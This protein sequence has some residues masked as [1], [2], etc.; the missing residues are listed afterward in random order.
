MHRFRFIARMR[1]VPSGHLLCIDT[2][3]ICPKILL[4]DNEDS[5]Q[6]ARMHKNAQ[7]QVHRTHAQSS[8]RAFAL[9][10]YILYMSKDSVSGQ[11]RLLSNCANAQECTYSGSSHACAKFY[12]GICSL[13][14][15][16]IV[17]NDSVSGQ[18]RAWTDCAK[19]GQFLLFSWTEKRV[20][21]MA[22]WRD[23]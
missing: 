19:G 4:A 9:H 20:F 3:Y 18:Q 12:P 10:R 6:T 8:I 15:H 13:L 21:V 17:S 14:I 2:F 22:E 11:R 23:I 1:K 5:Y 7:V 16:S